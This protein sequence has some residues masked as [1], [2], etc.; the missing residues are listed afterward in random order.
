MVSR[1]DGFILLVISFFVLS[2]LPISASAFSA[3]DFNIS[4]NNLIASLKSAIIFSPI[5][6]S[7]PDPPNNSPPP[8][9]NKKINSNVA[10]V[11][12]SF[13]VAV[14]VTRDFI[15]RALG[16]NLNNQP[17]I[18]N[19]TY[20]T[21]NQLSQSQNSNISRQLFDELARQVNELKSKGLTADR[22]PQIVQQ[23]LPVQEKIIIQKEISVPA[24]MG[25]LSYTKPEVDNKISSL[26]DR[27]SAVG[28]VAAVQNS[29][30][31]NAV[32]LTNKIDQLYQ[33]KLISPTITGGVTG[34]VASDIPALNY[35]SLSGGTF[36]GTTTGTGA[37]YS[38]MVGIGTTSPYAT[39]SVAGNMVVTGTTTFGGQA[40]QFPSSSGSS[41]QV[42]STNGAGVLSW[43]TTGAGSQTPWT[44]NI[45]G[46]GFTLSDVGVVTAIRFV[47]TSTSNA[48]I[49]PYASTTALSATNASTTNLTVSSI[50]SSLLKTSSTGLVTAATAGV[51]YL[52]TALASLGP[53]NASSTGPD[54]QLSTTT[55]IT[56]GITSAL[57]ITGSG[58]IIT[59]QPSQSGTLTVAG[60]GTG[61]ASFSTSG[62]LLYGSGI[63]A[64][65]E[66]GTST[67]AVDST[68]SVVS[69]SLGYQV[70]GSNVTIGLPA[71]A[72]SA[73]SYGSATQVPNYTVD[74]Q[75]RLTAAANTTIS[76]PTA[77]INNY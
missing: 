36:T 10:D 38:G 69:G 56:N 57:T 48:S 19:V 24:S 31:Y 71:T 53:I 67:V 5:T 41:G 52:T 65:Q 3:S 33:V 1:R 76:I 60:G 18:Q 73:G 37:I 44:Q 23:I 64:L 68:L 66:V 47:A 16:L 39:L 26:G 7:N 32:S 20:Q 15:I 46:G 13:R 8:S 75:G 54:I 40:L 21:V 61:A 35:M 11:Y 77:Q 55:S 17:T 58:N 9:E 42:L 43:I 22:V 59:F 63:N 25:T 30:T 62:K 2:G 72:V 4:K 74:A 6:T 45:D 34:L 29:A 70:G 28:N 51:D 27:I 50:L 12:G 49:F 14:E